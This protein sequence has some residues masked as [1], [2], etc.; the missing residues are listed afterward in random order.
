M[1]LVG[2]MRSGCPIFA[3]M[4]LQGFPCTQLMSPMAAIHNIQV[5]AAGWAHLA[6]PNGKISMRALHAPCCA[7]RSAPPH[8]CILLAFRGLRLWGWGL[9][10]GG[11]RVFSMHTQH[12][13]SKL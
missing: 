9:W 3:C 7:T 13:G 8:A 11:C 6:G 10:L 2:F 1:S 12:R 5:C 4:A